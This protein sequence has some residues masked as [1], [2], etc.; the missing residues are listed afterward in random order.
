MYMMAKDWY[1]LERNGYGSNFNEIKINP[2]KTMLVKYA[3]NTYAKT[4]LKKELNFFDFISK[5]KISLNIP[6]VREH[7]DEHILMDYIPKDQDQCNYN[8]PQIIRQLGTLH[9]YKP[10]KISLQQFT[11]VIYEET[12]TKIKSRKEEINNIVNKSHI[13]FVNGHKLLLFDEIINKLQEFIDIIIDSTSDYILC[14]IHGDPQYNNIIYS[15][16]KYF[17]IDPKGTFGSSDIYGLKEYDIAKLYF[18]ESGYDKF[19]NMIIDDT[20][21]ET[22]LHHNSLDIEFLKHPDGLLNE[23]KLV[24]AFYLSIWLSNAHIFAAK[25]PNKVL[26]SYYS[27]LYFASYHITQNNLSYLLNK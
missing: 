17:F 12:I 10:M 3:L 20:Y 9:K 6:N 25:Q 7:S 2:D 16:N 11:Q 4:K 21:F 15:Q 27:A 22:N 14:P 19:D 26:I 8:I 1:V 23:H 13:K 5:N 18:S 24:L